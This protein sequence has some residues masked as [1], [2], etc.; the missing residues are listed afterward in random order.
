MGG[1]SPPPR[2]GQ[3]RGRCRRPRPVLVDRPG[4]AGGRPVL[5]R[6][7]AGAG[8]NRLY[9]DIHE[10]PMMRLTQIVQYGGAG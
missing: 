5:G 10:M 7:L 3:P 9:N 1:S 8:Q 2:T 6:G 4:T